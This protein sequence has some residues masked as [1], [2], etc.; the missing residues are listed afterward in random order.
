MRITYTNGKTTE[1]IIL[2]RNERIMRIALK[3]S[4]DVTEFA[5]VSGEWV[6]EDLEP[7]HVRYEWQRR[8]RKQV[9]TEADCV[10]SK[11]LASGLIQLLLSGEEA[12][13]QTTARVEVFQPV[14]CCQ[15]VA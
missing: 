14:A 5:I 9:V 11:E 13:L 12:N 2:S 1:G 7:V 3:G 8:S 10:C 6:S 15:S 4:E